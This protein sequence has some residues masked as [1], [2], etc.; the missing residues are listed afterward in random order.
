M[1]LL[2]LMLPDMDGLDICRFVTGEKNIPSLS[3]P[4]ETTRWIS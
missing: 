4:P 2:D 1:I 3:F